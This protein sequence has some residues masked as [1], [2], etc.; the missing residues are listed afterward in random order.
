MKLS[1]CVQVHKLQRGQQDV[2]EQIFNDANIP[3]PDLL[4]NSQIP[5]YV[6]YTKLY[7]NY[8]LGVSWWTTL[9]LPT[10]PW[11]HFDKAIPGYRCRKQHTIYRFAQP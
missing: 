10:Q 3:Q 8:V 1:A 6:Y 11:Q 4:K 7:Q 9:F 2:S 5:T